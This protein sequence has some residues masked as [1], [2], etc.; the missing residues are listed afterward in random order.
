MKQ[1][2]VIGRPISVL[3][4]PSINECSLYRIRKS[5]TSAP[6]NIEYYPQRIDLWLA[7][8]IY[9]RELTMDE[10]YVDWTYSKQ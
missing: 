9:R 10:E 3:G 2:V 4:R 8:Q 6:L 5:M 7:R 1:T